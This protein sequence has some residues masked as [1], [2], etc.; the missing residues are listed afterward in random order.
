[1]RRLPYG[2]ANPKEYDPRKTRNLTNKLDECGAIS[3][4][5]TLHDD[6]GESVGDGGVNLF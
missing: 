4:H 1:M 2:T 6:A 3:L 5:L